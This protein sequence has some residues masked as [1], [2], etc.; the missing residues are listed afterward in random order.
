MAVKKTAFLVGALAGGSVAVAAFAGA[1]MKLPA[2]WNPAARR[3]P[4]PGLDR[5]GLR[6]GARR[7][8]VVR[9]HLRAGLARRGLDPRDLEDRRL[10][11]APADPR[12][13]ELPVRDRAAKG[14]DD[15][16][17]AAEAAIVRLRLLHL[18]RRLHR[19]QQPRRRRR[20]GD[21]GGD[22]GRRRADRH[23]GRPRRGH[24][25][26]RAQGARATTS[27]SCRFE[28]AV[29]AAGR[30][31]GGGGRQPVRPRRH[32]HRRHRLGLWPRHRR[33]TSSTTSRSTRRSTRA[34]PAARPSTSTAG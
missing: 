15:D 22:Q 25:P 6:P 23:G 3:Q 14:G 21:Q 32:R 30:R 8:A 5:A 7:A 31:L 26:G 17:S 18:G 16:A 2:A 4:D 24:R 34:T 29:R 12:L 9:R 28:T 13:R 19:H 27:R 10:G 33:R 20:R 1:G 11:A